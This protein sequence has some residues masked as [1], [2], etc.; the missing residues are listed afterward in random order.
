MLAGIALIVGVHGGICRIPRD[1]RAW[2]LVPERESTK[3]ESGGA[4]SGCRRRKLEGNTLVVAA[5]G[6]ANTVIVRLSTDLRSSEF[7]AITWNVQGVPADAAVYMLWKSDIGGSRTNQVP[8]T[9]ESGRLRT[10]VL[11]GNPA[12]LGR[13]QAL[14]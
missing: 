13:I 1:G 5:G 14:R 6:A 8:V 4:D 3:L 12:W 11:A 7:P 10:V 2:R 9:V